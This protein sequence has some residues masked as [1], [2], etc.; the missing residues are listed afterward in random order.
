MKILVN[1]ENLLNVVSDVL[2]RLD[3]IDSN[4]AFN[5]DTD[6][7]ERGYVAGLQEAKSI[8]KVWLYDELKEDLKENK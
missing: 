7:Y 8:V 4:I 6:D 5:P 3:E 2:N 1:T